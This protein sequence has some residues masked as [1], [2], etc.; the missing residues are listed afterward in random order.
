M[1]HYNIR[2]K[3]KNDNNKMGLNTNLEGYTEIYKYLDNTTNR[4]LC[5]TCNAILS[6]KGLQQ[7]EISHNN[8]NNVCR[9]SNL[10][11]CL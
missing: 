3:N 9:M 4:V 10:Q 11:G 7:T 8:N 6:T 2:K 5:K 1:I